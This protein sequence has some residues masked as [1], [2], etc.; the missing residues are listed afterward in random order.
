MTTILDNHS[1]LLRW[2]LA[3]ASVAAALPIAVA[4]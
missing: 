3:K 2:L 1:D 4:M